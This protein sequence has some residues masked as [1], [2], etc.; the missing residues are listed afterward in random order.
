MR[1]TRSVAAA[2]DGDRLDDFA[3]T[4]VASD[5]ALA[6]TAAADAD[7]DQTESE[8]EAEAQENEKLHDSDYERGRSKKKTQRKKQ[9]GEGSSTPPAAAAAAASASA[10]ASASSA[11]AADESQQPYG[12]S[13][14]PWNVY[15]RGNNWRN[16]VSSHIRTF[17]LTP[18]DIR[19]PRN[20]HSALSLC[21][22]CSKSMPSTV[23]SMRRVQTD[24]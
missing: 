22:M 14:T 20:S 21:F 17:F 23:Q 2:A 5:A 13:R 24:C 18:A 12:K 7:E 19:S 6:A 15:T 4:A 8:A 9:K 10:S 16:N 3:A 1:K 11:A